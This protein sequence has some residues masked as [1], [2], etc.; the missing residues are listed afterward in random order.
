MDNSGRFQNIN[1]SGNN[2]IDANEES[3]QSQASEKIEIEHHQQQ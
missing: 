2:N 3:Q 1:N